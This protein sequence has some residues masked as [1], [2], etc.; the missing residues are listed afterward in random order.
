MIDW[1]LKFDSLESLYN[2]MREAYAK[3]AG[4]ATNPVEPKQFELNV[5]NDYE[6]LRPAWEQAKQMQAQTSA[7]N[8]FFKY[9]FGGQEVPTFETNYNIMKGAEPAIH[10]LKPSEAID[11]VEEVFPSKGLLGRIGKAESRMGQDADTYRTGYYGG[12]MQVDKAGWADTMD[13]K[14]HP[15]LKSK[16][17]KIQDKF[18]IDWTKTT[19]KDMRDPL[20]SAIAARLL[21]STKPSAIPEDI[22]KQAE[23]WKKNYNTSAGAG[24]PEHFIEANK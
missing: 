18:G 23:Y 11:Q 9:Y 22:N 1:L 6:K 17:K 8:D 20:H 15:S 13:I 5:Q 2:G 4:D 12:F 7:E 10:A 24:T 21:L 16:Y 14:S 3:F 19:W